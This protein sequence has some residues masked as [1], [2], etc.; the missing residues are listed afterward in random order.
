LELE[1]QDRLTGTEAILGSPSYMAPEQAAGH[2]SEVGTAADVYALGA[3]L[4]ELL[5]GR[6]PFKAATML[7]TLE[8]VKTAPVG[9]PSR[10]QPGLPRDVETICLK[11][12]RKE[13]ARRYASALEL[14]EDLRR[15]QAGEPIL[16]RRTSLAERVWLW[17]RRNPA[18]AALTTAVVLLL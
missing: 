6:P 1:A 3:I 16:A 5:T 9:P 10:L 8:Q 7:E 2:I 14:A 18:L 12:L 15:F 4:Y 17:C 13:P 11:G